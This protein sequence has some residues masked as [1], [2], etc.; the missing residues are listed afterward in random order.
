MKKAFA[1]FLAACCIFTGI[2]FAFPIVADEA[3][4]RHRQKS[5]LQLRKTFSKSATMRTFP[6]TEAIC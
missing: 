5:K 1:L 2:S 6:L 4:M 3:E